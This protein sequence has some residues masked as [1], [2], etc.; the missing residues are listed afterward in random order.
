MFDLT[1]IGEGLVGLFGA[2][3]EISGGSALDLL[4]QAGLDP[5]QLSGLGPQEVMDVLSQN[6]IDISQLAPDQLQE[7]GNMLGF[8]GNLVGSATDIASRF[9]SR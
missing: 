1:R 3:R 9:L 2:A 8:G 6:G 7:L 4:Q 5:S